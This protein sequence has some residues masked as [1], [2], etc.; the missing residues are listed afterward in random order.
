MHIGIYQAYWG[1]VGGGQRY[2]GV[3]AQVLARRHAVEIVHHCE[4]FDQGRVAEGLE[5]DLDGVSFRCVPRPPRPEHPAG[6]PLKRLRQER[7]LGR[8]I[9]EP[10]DVFI[11]SSDNVPY[12]C[13]APTG[14]L[15]VHFPLVT[16]ETFHGHGTDE[17]RQRPAVM[18]KLTAL[19]HR[20]EWKKRFATYGLTLC[21][22]QFTRRW[23]RARWGRDAAVVYPPTRNS[24]TPATKDRLILNIAAFDASGHKKHDV[25]V[26]SFKGVCD[27]GLAGW[28]LILVGALRPSAEN[29]AYLERLQKEAAGYPVSF[30]TNASTIELRKL[31][32]GAAVYWHAMGHGVD[33][34][35]DPGRMEHF[36]MVATEAM[37]AGCV[38]IVYNGG[39]LPESVEHGKSGFLWGTLDELGAHTRAVAGDDA[40]R[41]RLGRA[42]Q[43]RATEFSEEKFAERLV[44][45]LGPVLGS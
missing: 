20:L 9:S 21:N 12:F 43:V 39:G 30:R 24:F 44:G 29:Q 7:E 23:L 32:E 10:Y 13:H 35:A 31:L 40:L 22:S 33:P 37:A 5:V 19:Y 45:A 4:T 17:W 38:P 28:E 6:N 2:V 25:L 11:D 16:F 26:D 18:K 34:E 8:E 27:A 1:Q 3:A 14:V 42:A 41:A 15:L 36:G